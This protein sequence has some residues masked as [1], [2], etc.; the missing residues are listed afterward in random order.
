MKEFIEVKASKASLAQRKLV[1]GVGINDAMYTVNNEGLCCPYYIQWHSIIQ[2]C[3][4]FSK[5]KIYKGC[6]VHKEWH[7]FMNFRRW[8]E[9]QNWKNMYL[10]KDILILGNKEYG[11]KTCVFVTNHINTMFQQT[12]LRKLPKGTHKQGKKY[13]ARCP[14]R[15]GIRKYIGIFNTLEEAN[16]MYIKAKAKVLADEFKSI[17]DTRVKDGLRRLLLELDKENKRKIIMLAQPI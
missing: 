12:K 8:M 7:Y 17:A 16:D 13:I 15:T 5:R 6:Y 4:K 1:C 3:Y 14:D 9:N 2:R 10:D 11:P